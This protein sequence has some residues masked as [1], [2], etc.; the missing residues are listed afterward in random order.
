MLSSCVFLSVESD[1]SLLRRFD[2]HRPGFEKFIAL[3]EE[4]GLFSISNWNGRCEL[5]MEP[6]KFSQEEL[7]ALCAERRRIG[8]ESIYG[9]EHEIE[10]LATRESYTEYKSY[11]FLTD[12]PSPPHFLVEDLDDVSTLGAWYRHIEGNWYLYFRRDD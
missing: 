11:V 12:S 6:R 1:R 4:K 7:E 5:A 8:V 10:F 2:R 3:E 9:S